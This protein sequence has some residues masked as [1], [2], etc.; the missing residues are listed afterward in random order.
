VGFVESVSVA[1]SLALRRGQRITPNKE[2]LGLGAANIASAVSGGYPVTGGFARS[3]VNFAA[4]AQTPLAGVVS[5]LLMVLVVGTLTGSLAPLPHAALAATIIIAVSSL[6]DTETLRHTWRHDRADALALIATAGGVI[7]VGVEA[8]IIAGVVLSLAVLVWRGSR[9][10]IAVIG[11]VPGTEHFRNIERHPVQTLPGLLAVRIDESLGFTNAAMIE[12]WLVRRL[13]AEADIRTVL[14]VCSAINRIDSTGL[15]MLTRLESDLRARGLRLMLS[16][17]KGPVMDP[18]ADTDFGRR[19][20]DRIF[21][22]THQAFLAAS[23]DT[24]APCPPSASGP[25]C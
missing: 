14:L 18:L 6:I 20:H 24:A 7:L 1:Q 9:P 19:M 21:L 22:S 25:V 23:G 16:E 13:S 5:A 2:L 4:G 12:D 10:H 17:V 11:R 15:E 3:V 8:G